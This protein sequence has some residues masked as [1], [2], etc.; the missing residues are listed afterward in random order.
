[1]DNSELQRK[2]VVVLPT[3]RGGGAERLHLNLAREWIAKGIRVEFALLQREGELLGLVPEGATIH[4]LNVSRIRSSVLPLRRYLATATPDVTIAAMWPLTLAAVVAWRLAGKPGKLLISDHTQLSIACLKELGTPRWLLSWCIRLLY[5]LASRVVAVSKGVKEDLC[6]L[7]SLDPSKVSV[8]YNP[9]ALEVLPVE[10]AQLLAKR[11]WGD[12]PCLKILA[13]GTL[14]TQKD[15]ATLLRA[16][17]LLPG[18]VNAKLIVLGSGPLLGEL[19]ELRHQLGLDKKVHFA[20][21]K[22]DPSDWYRTADVFVLSSRW[23]GFANVIVEALS[24]GLPV[25]STNCPSGPSEILEDG[26]YGTLVEPGNPA[27]LAETIAGSTMR[28]WDRASLVLRSRDFSN[29]KIAGEYLALMNAP[30]RA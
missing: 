19:L 6:R 2:I 17:A 16:M 27:M 15:H 8:I 21:F 1:M 24:F 10:D 14:K 5:P 23:E 25:I 13:V 9:T 28:I 29:D 12:V 11:I 30:D 20:G 7:G 4:E 3:L 18:A 26:R 22:A